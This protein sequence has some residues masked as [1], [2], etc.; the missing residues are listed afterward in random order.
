MITNTTQQR[1]LRGHNPTRPTPRAANTTE[2]RAMLAWRL[3]PRDKWLGRMLWEHRVLT[4]H[5]LTDLAFTGPRKTR[6]RLRELFLLGVVDRFQPFVTTGSSPMHYVL[7][8]AGAA[9]LAAEDGLDIKELGYRHDRAFGVAH[10]LRLAHTAGVNGWFTALIAHARHSADHDT[11]LTA[12]WSERRCARH[13]GDLVRPDGY[14]RWHQAGRAI[15]WFLEYDTGTEPLGK[16]AAKLTGYAALAHSTG[17]TTPLLVWT[18]TSRRE[19]GARRALAAAWRELDEP[20]SVP[21]ATAAAE[22]LDP[23]A[24]HPGPADPIWL[25]LDNR[26]GG[27]RRGLA[28]LTGAWPHIAPPVPP[29]GDTA[30]G[31]EPSATMMPAPHPMPPEPG[32]HSGRR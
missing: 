10:S 24:S 5:H 25:P 32:G 14:G 13:F 8:P 1:S 6:V 23:N 3:T 2:H 12:W 21:V 18:L 26:A 16:L 4:T 19:A 11:A 17:I 15:E 20:A 30:L 29:G 22:L 27:T 9:V 31:V 28:E 7:A